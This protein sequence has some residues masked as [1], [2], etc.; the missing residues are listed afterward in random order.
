MD[1]DFIA[2][3][4]CFYEFGHRSCGFVSMHSPVHN[5]QGINTLE[6]ENGHRPRKKGHTFHKQL[7]VALMK[8]F[9]RKGVIYF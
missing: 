1:R 3:L 8:H 4:D 6:R 9:P 7:L 2:I 5:N